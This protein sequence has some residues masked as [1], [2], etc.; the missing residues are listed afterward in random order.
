MRSDSSWSGSRCEAPRSDWPPAAASLATR[1]ATL[2]RCREASASNAEI[3]V[4]VET[5]PRPH[6]VTTRGQHCSSRSYTRISQSF[7]SRISSGA[8][9][10]ACQLAREQG[11]PS[12]YTHT[13]KHTH[14]HAHTHTHTHTHAHTHTHTHTR[15]HTHTHTHLTI[16]LSPQLRRANYQTVNSMSRLRQHHIFGLPGNLNTD[17]ARCFRTLRSLWCRRQHL[18]HDLVIRRVPGLFRTGRDRLEETEHWHM[19]PFSHWYRRRQNFDVNSRI[20]TSTSKF[21]M[22]VWTIL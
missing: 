5:S 6:V 8:N 18:A 9:V 4:T 21:N 16:T 22:T 12:L 13:Q 10:V 1:L 15:T 11:Q 2:S 7:F 19:K 20:L 17:L 14:T 3:R